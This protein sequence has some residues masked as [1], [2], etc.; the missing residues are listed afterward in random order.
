MR[1]FVTRVLAPA[2][3][4]LST[5]CSDYG[6]GS[7]CESVPPRATDAG[8]NQLQLQCGR[9]PCSYGS[10]VPQGS[11][12][13][14]VA[15]VNCPGVSDEFL[16]AVKVDGKLLALKPVT[17]A[18]YSTTIVVDAGPW[19]PPD[20]LWHEAEVVIDPLNL[21][22][23]NDESNN[24]GSARIRVVLPD[25][26]LDPTGCG[27]R[28][29]FSAGGTG[30]FVTQV[31]FG[32]PVEVVH[33]M[34]LGGPYPQ[35]VARSVRSGTIFEASD[36]MAITGQCAFVRPDGL[37]MITPWTPPAVGDYDVEFRIEPLGPVLDQRP[38]N[39]SLI[40]RLSVTVASRPK[41][42]SVGRRLRAGVAAR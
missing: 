1:R 18:G 17:A 6:S 11:D 8:F 3:L 16:V 29:P 22:P 25:A 35:G 15:L 33:A 13:H 40:R 23:E 34:M 14:V 9:S 20:T 42:V 5:A 31:P 26:A 10:E 12:P 39:N 28:V 38:A 30:A 19:N 21:F 32:T 4:G 7:G 2:I 37:T 24:R 41:P 27:F 36:T